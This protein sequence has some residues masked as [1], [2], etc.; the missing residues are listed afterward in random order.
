MAACFAGQS[1][2]AVTLGIR[3]LTSRGVVENEW[4]LLQKYRVLGLAIISCSTHRR[5]R[6]E[7]GLQFRRRAELS[8]R[9]ANWFE[10]SQ[11]D[12]QAR[13]WLAH[14]VYTTILEH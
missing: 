4:Q 7:L 9:A 3:F 13:N 2:T 10:G 11:F 6:V 14:H 1:D 5:H 8:H 12:F